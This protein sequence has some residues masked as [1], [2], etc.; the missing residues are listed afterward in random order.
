MLSASD[1]FGGGHL[2]GE[3]PKDRGA[4]SLKY[5][6]HRMGRTELLATLTGR[7]E[8]LKHLVAHLRGQRGVAQPRHLFLYGPR[9]IGKTTLL[10]ALRYSIEGDPGLREAFE[11]VQLSEEERR[12]SNLPSFAF[13]LLE[14]LSS[15]CVSAGVEPLR[16]LL[17]QAQ[18]EPDSALDRLIEAGKRLGGKQVV[19]LL[20][21]FDELAIAAVSRKQR[22]S[23]ATSQSPLARLQGLFEQPSFL[24]VA[25]A[26]RDPARRRDFPRSLLDRFEQ[27]IHIGPVTGAVELVRKR[28]ALAGREEEILQRP[29]IAAR[30]AGLN[31][32]TGG[33]PRLLVY[34]YEHLDALQTLDLER[35]IQQ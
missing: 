1:N 19:F 14:L 22:P 34:L 21:N 32:L 20:D 16:V 33:N 30:L 28:A 24:F 35:V 23:A 12:V 25:T 11:V 29:G 7:E 5:N 9:G 3:V 10:L 6:P 8:I 2:G 4:L 27:P 15:V 17:V 26:L 18:K 13:R 31:R